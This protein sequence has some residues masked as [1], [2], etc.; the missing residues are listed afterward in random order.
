VGDTK[1]G[2]RIYADVALQLSAYDR[3][4]FAVIDGQRVDI[5]PARRGAVLHLRED[6]YDLH[7]VRID[8]EV[9]DVFL[10]AYDMYVWANDTSYTVVRGPMNG[11]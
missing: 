8:D 3:A 1:T 11:L 7:P 2:K 9:F 10:A 4:D 6:G 5:A